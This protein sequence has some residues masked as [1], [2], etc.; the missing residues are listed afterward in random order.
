MYVC[1]YMHAGMYVFV[2]PL[3]MYISKVLC[4]YMWI[5]ACM[6]VYVDM[7][8]YVCICRYVCKTV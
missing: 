8:M 2:G 7:C 1:I 3:C 6:Y 4:R 5:C